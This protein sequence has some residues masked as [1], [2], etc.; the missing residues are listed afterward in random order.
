MRLYDKIRVNTMDNEE[1]PRKD[2]GNLYQEVCIKWLIEEK[3]PIIDFPVSIGST[4]YIVWPKDD[5]LPECGYTFD[6]VGRLVGLVDEIRFF[7][8]YTGNYMLVGDMGREE[9]RHFHVLPQ[10]DED[11]LRDRL[12]ICNG[13]YIKGSE[14]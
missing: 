6:E 2:G 10:E 12:N 7:Q 8:R 11:I 3:L 13:E 1:Y 4:G 9:T 14:D 5:D